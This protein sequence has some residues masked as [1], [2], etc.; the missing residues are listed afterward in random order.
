MDSIIDDALEILKDT[1]PEFGQGFS[2]HGPMASE[3]MITLGRPQHVVHWAE[4]YRKR[5]RPHPEA[6]DPITKDNWREAIGKHDRVGDWVVYFRNQLKENPWQ[7]LIEKWTPMLAPGMMAGGTHGIIRT[8]HAVRSL[9]REETDL[10]LNELAEGLAYW[11]SSFLHLPGVRDRGSGYLRPKEAI[12]QVP[13]VPRE[14]LG[15][16]KLIEESMQALEYV[17]F[18]GVVNTIDV[19]G[20]PSKFISELTEITAAC[21]LANASHIG[22]AITFIHSVTAPAMLRLLLPHIKAEDR[23]A[24]LS[25]C[26]QTAMGLYSV[27]G[28]DGQFGG[29]NA[30]EETADELIDRAVNTNDEHAI[31]FAE[32]CLREH[33]FNPKPIYLAATSHASRLIGKEPVSPATARC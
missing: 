6:L 20:D 4:L 32:A 23:D 26:W 18:E 24:V 30:V 12:E 3:A 17:D 19:T 31:K 25:Y 33:S 8:G 11:T 1:G 15:K 28:Q 5:L 14:E 22:H 10:R 13:I 29:C 7:S 21:F 9:T 27:S 16:Y 2:N